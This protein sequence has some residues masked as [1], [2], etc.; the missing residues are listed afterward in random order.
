M[1]KRQYKKL[2]NR[3]FIKHYKIYEQVNE[4]MNRLFPPD[5][6]KRLAEIQ[7]YAMWQPFK[8]VEESVQ[9]ISNNN[10]YIRNGGD[11]EY[12]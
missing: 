9:F 3:D 2:K 10:D 7:S 1:N 8:N 11:I 4:E 5:M 12:E 6:M